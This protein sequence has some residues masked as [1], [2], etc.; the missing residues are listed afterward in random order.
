MAKNIRSRRRLSKIP[1]I[2][3]SLSRSLGVPGCC[4]V[5]YERTGRGRFDPPDRNFPEPVP[6][7]KSPPWNMGQER[8]A[9]RRN[10]LRSSSVSYPQAFAGELVP[11][12]SEYVSPVPGLYERQSLLPSL[13]DWQQNDPST[14]PSRQVEPATPLAPLQGRI[15]TCHFAVAPDL[16]IECFPFTRSARSTGRRSAPCFERE[17]KSGSV[18]H[19]PFLDI[20]D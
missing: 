5:P 7:K 17:R 18:Q 3:F 15:V 19:P 8:M 20:P 11:N 2:A 4:G 16:R 10:G 9:Y 14:R 1:A 12:Q 13:V 6:N